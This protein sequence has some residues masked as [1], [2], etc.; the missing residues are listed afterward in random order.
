MQ[1]LQKT[2]LANTLA[3]KGTSLRLT[4][5]RSFSILL[6]LLVIV[7]VS[8]IAV[9]SIMNYRTAREYQA[10]AA[11]KNREA[12]EKLEENEA[13]ERRLNDENLDEYFEK[14]ARENGYM[15]P[16]ERVVFDSSYGN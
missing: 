14:I 11:Q 6:L 8:V 15:R 9:S 16:G 1:T 7:F 2:T 3:K 12:Q 4:P 5:K 10:E 13:L